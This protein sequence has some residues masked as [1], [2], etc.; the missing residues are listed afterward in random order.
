MYN[1]VGHELHQIGT[2]LV[3][4]PTTWQQ[5]EPYEQKESIIFFF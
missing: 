1:E 2:T 3:S 5:D 4:H